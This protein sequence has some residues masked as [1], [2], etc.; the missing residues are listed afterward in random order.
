M[1]NVALSRL[2][3]V[4]R[5]SFQMVLSIMVSGSATTSR[6]TEFRGGPTEHATKECGRTARPVA[7]ASFG[8][9]MATCL[10]A[11][12]STIKLMA[13]ASTH[14]QME[15]AIAATGKTI[16]SM[17]RDASSGSTAASTSANI[18]WAKST[19]TVNTG[20]PMA[21]P[22]TASGS[23]IKYMARA[24]TCGSMAEPTLVAG[25]ITI[26]MD[27]GPMCGRMVASIKVSLRM[28]RNMATVFMNGLI[29]GAMKATGT[30][31]NSMV[32]VATFRLT[33]PRNREFGIMA[34]ARN[35]SKSHLTQQKVNK[36]I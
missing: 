28:I 21:A 24:P 19:A 8:T 12:G 1:L 5:L 23:I 22:T 31:V 15:P 16:C 11:S 17:G 29:S 36:Q 33:A 6:G 32:R 14:T 10:K 34:V 20:G 2:N 9:S 25:L 27:R 7:K 4:T 35:G 30:Q 3:S 26:W 18:K 13:M